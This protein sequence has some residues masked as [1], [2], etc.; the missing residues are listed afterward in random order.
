MIHGSHMRADAPETPP[1]ADK[2]ATVAFTLP[3]A[4][5]FGLAAVG[6]ALVHQYGHARSWSS[7]LEIHR[8]GEINGNN[9]FGS[10]SKILYKRST[11]SI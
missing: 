2:T 9:S 6:S 5:A 11:L 3:G 7:T 8:L 10:T 1:V 4:A